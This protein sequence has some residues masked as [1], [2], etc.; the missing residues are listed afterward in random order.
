M[1]TWIIVRKSDMA[2]L[3][4]YQ[5]DA[6]DDTSTN[7]DY[8]Q[9]EPLAA[10][11]ELP[12]GLE[13]DTV[14]AAMVED[15]IVL[16]EDAEKASAKEAK[17]WAALRAERDSRL[18][19]CDWTQ[20]EDAPLALDKKAEWAAYRQE[21]RDVPEDTVDPTAPVWPAQP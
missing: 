6:K 5:A 10:H 8:Q 16:S 2:I 19:A 7:R 4:N 17:E 1:S 11:I 3:G 9:A 13:A 18:Q 14:S 15:A 12:E 21:L 20:L